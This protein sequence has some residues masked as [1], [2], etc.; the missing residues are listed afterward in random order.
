MV[1][2]ETFASIAKLNIVRVLLSIVV[3]LDWTLQ[4][5]NVKNTFLNGDLEEDVYMDSPLRFDGNYS[6]KVW[7]L[8]NCLYDLKQSLR[9]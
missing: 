4:Q 6:S 2:Y 8:R 7:K 1:Y 3:N 9:A 5:L